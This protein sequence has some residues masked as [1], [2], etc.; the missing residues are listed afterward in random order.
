MPETLDMNQGGG[1]FII[2]SSPCFVI[3]S[4]VL[5]FYP[6]ASVSDRFPFLAFSPLLDFC[7][8]PPIF[9]EKFC[10]HGLNAPRN[11]LAFLR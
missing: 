5:P 11:R 8:C 7:T 4:R 6:G 2:V 1:R 3:G 10:L 9:R